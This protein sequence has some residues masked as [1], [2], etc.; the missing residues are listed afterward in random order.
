MED[1][2]VEGAYLSPSSEVDLVVLSLY[3]DISRFWAKNLV[4]LDKFH[5][6]KI[7][8]GS[9]VNPAS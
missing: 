9:L 7:Y 8:S 3:V 4:S 6:P 2:D 1:S 5:L